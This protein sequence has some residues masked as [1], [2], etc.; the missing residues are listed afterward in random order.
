MQDNTK[1]GKIHIL[2]DNTDILDNDNLVDF[3][4]EDNCYVNDKFIGTTVA[5]K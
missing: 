1:T 3:S 4:I 5:K 2:D